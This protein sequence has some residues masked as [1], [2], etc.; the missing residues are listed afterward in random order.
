MITSINPATE[1]V[2]AEF[3]PW[4][5]D[6]VDHAV[7]QVV[8][9]QR[10]WR[11]MSI[12]QRAVPMRRAAELLRQRSERYGALITSEMGKPIVEAEAEVEKCATAC[13]HYADHAAEY[14]ADAP[15]ATESLESYVA[16]EPLGTILAIMPWNFP[17]W[18]VF[19][20]GA[21]ALMAGNGIVLKHASNVPQSALACEQV[22]RDAGFPDG[23][24]RTVLISGADTERADRRRAH[25][26]GDADRLLRGRCADRLAGRGAHQEAGAGARRIG[27]VHRPRRCRPR[28]RGAYR[29]ARAEPE[30][31]PELHRR[32]ALHRGGAGR[33]RVRRP[34]RRRGSR[35]ARRR[36]G[37]ARHERRPAGAR[38]PARHPRA[39]GERI[40]RDGGPAARRRRAH[41][42]ARLLLRADRAGRRH[43]RHARLPRGDVRPR[44]GAA[45]APG[46]S[47]TPSSS[48]TTPSTGW[49]PPSGRATSRPPRRSRGASR[50]ARCSS[51]AWSPRIRACRS[52]A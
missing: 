20:A 35:A 3:E 37:V 28:R 11:K 29:G 24:F 40:A 43:G 21:P 6:T 51:T 7:D 10:A 36:P 17:F 50:Q 48:P 30:Q 31:R 38:G 33:R 23:L 26:G 52:A 15:V 22:L 18:Q 5:D 42:R 16:Y 9:A 39:P 47:T 12:E 34:L 2:L 45:S 32:Q 14:L 13:D 44:R 8:A 4:S 41:R 27:P 46:T 49:A 1:E 19:R 25:R